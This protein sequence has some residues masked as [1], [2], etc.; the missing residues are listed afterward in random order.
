M[1]EKIYHTNLPTYM[2]QKIMLIRQSETRIN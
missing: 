1:N 2:I